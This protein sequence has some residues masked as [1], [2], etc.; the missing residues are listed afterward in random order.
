MHCYDRNPRQNGSSHR[1][2]E[3]GW[4]SQ[5]KCPGKVPWR[6]WD[7]SWSPED[8]RTL[9]DGSGSGQRAARAGERQ[10]QGHNPQ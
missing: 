2:W 10:D 3:K 5:V 8:D 1:C 7:A 6:R 4:V 9:T